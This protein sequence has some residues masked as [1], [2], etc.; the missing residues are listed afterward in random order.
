MP[1]LATSGINPPFGGLSPSLGQVAYVLLNRLPLGK[2]ANSLAPLDLH[3][4]GTPLA[5]VLSQDQTLHP[6]WIP[7]KTEVFREKRV[8]L[9]R[10]RGSREAWSRPAFKRFRFRPTV[11]FSRIP[12]TTDAKNP[13]SPQ[14]IQMGILLHS[15]SLTRGGSASLLLSTHRLYPSRFLVSTSY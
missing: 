5:F 11:Q 9:S 8:R 7:P 10:C 12:S 6:N 2:R 13:R 14:A 1:S 15:V 4:L 3:T